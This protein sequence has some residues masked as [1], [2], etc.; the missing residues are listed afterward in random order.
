MDKEEHNIT[1]L[2]NII[3]R[4][5][6][7][8]SIKESGE[9]IFEPIDPQKAKNWGG[10]KIL[11]LP[12]SFLGWNSYFIRGGGYTNIILKALEVGFLELQ[13]SFYLGVF[14][15]TA[16]WVAIWWLSPRLRGNLVGKITPIVL[17]CLSV[18][19]GEYITYDGNNKVIDA[20]KE[21]R[22]K[23]EYVESQ[24]GVG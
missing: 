17:F 7:Y 19:A 23:I 10:E 11:K 9:Q 4:N 5:P 1:T 20:D 2:Q 13:V 16:G 8:K 21:Q 14:S 15:Y 22:E 24:E 18:F 6:D 12:T 3:V